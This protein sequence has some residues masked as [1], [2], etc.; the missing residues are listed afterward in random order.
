MWDSEPLNE[1][2]YGF[3]RSGLDSSDHKE[4]VTM[5]F[6]AVFAIVVGIGMIVQWAVSYAAKQIPELLTEP[7]RIRFHIAGEILTALALIGGGTGLLAGW[8]WAPTLFFVS[9]GMLFYTAIVSPGFFAQRDERIW[10]LLF[11][12]LILIGLLA[13]FSVHAVVA[14]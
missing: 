12:V 2:A 5:T 4:L 9:M 1:C 6:S 13:V 7:I 14:A 11:G 8:P 10:V 3:D